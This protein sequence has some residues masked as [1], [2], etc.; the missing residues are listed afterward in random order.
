MGEAI[1]F[2][3]ALKNFLG[4]SEH[5]CQPALK[6]LARKKPCHGDPGRRRAR[7]CALVRRRQHPWMSRSLLKR[8]LED[9]ATVPLKKSPRKH[10]GKQSKGALRLSLVPRGIL[11]SPPACGAELRRRPLRALLRDLLW[12][13]HSFSTADS[14][15]EMGGQRQNPSRKNPCAHTP[16]QTQRPEINMPSLLI[17]GSGTKVGGRKHI[18]WSLPFRVRDTSRAQKLN[19]EFTT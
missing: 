16:I 14:Q 12:L 3:S 8:H 6:D 15:L 5:T 9:V 19:P 11:Q 2:R 18:P 4:S 1:L 17:S 10:L 7:W 13:P